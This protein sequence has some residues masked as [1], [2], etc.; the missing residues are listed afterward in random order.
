[1]RQGGLRALAVLGE[2]RSPALPN[3]PSAPEAGLPG[4]I[5]EE[6]FPILAPAATPAPIVAALGVAFRTA[7]QQSAPRLT[8]VAGVAPRPGFE[9]SEQIMRLVADGVQQYSTILRNAGVRPE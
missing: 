9:T 3:V 6:F 1:V 2:Q 7:I 4:V 8:E 5:L